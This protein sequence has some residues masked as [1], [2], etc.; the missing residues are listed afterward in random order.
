MTAQDTSATYGLD[1]DEWSRIVERLGREPSAIE[2]KIF[3]T[4]WSEEV[5]FKSSASILK[6]IENSFSSLYPL[7]G[8][9][10]G[11]LA[12]S[13]SLRLIAKCSHNDAGFRND[14]LNGLP[15][16]LGA[17]LLATA[18]RGATSLGFSSRF[19]LPELDKSDA[20]SRFQSAIASVNDFSQ[21]SGTLQSETHWQIHENYAGN[22]ICDSLCIGLRETTIAQS[23]PMTDDP[24]LIIGAQT[25]NERLRKANTSDAS[26]NDTTPPLA[27]PFLHYRISKALQELYNEGLLSAAVALHYGGLAVGVIRLADLISSVVEI[28]LN[29]LP[30]V[31]KNVSAEQLLFS[32]S[33]GR[34]LLSVSK[35]QLRKVSQIFSKWEVAQQTCGKI[36]STLGLEIHYNH[37]IIADIPLK[38]ALAG[39]SNKEFNVVKFP[40]MLKAKDSVSRQATAPKKYQKK[41]NDEWSF[42]RDAT[43]TSSKAKDDFA[44]PKNLADTWVDVLAN[45]NFASR[46]LALQRNDAFLGGNALIDNGG[47]GRLLAL[48]QTR[49]AQIALALASAT[50]PLYTSVDPYLGMTHSVAQAMRKIA[51]L[52]ATPLG[53][54][55]ALHYGHPDKY[56]DV[57]DLS[58]SIRALGD[59]T[60]HWQIPILDGDISLGNGSEAYPLVATPAISM[61]GRADIKTS[62]TLQLF[63][64]E[65]NLFFLIGESSNEYTCSEYSRYIHHRVNPNNVPNINFD[66]E[67]ARAQQI[68]KLIQLNLVTCC[69]TLTAG[70]LSY[71]LAAVLLGAQKPLGAKLKLSIKNPRFDAQLFGE[72]AGRY[73]LFTTAENYDALAEA[74]TKE[75]IP[76]EGAGEV[77][78]REIELSGS[79]RCTLPVATAYRIWN[80]A[81]ERALA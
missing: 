61:V 35:N 2:A 28:D 54:S 27:D 67:Y 50:T 20:L 45:L 26:I 57:C 38:F 63:P 7:P 48:R 32:E 21:L 1:K 69:R 16:A 41:E 15:T 65:G 10:G 51:A 33:S 8:T 53:I 66:L 3:A 11:E 78:G 55:F 12:I 14:P 73:L 76:I 17:T 49:D 80:Q 37:K 44:E 9:F 22:A 47:D 24:I 42:I 29:R 36:S 72:S 62:S 5:S 25:G 68:S 39:G 77:T 64:E 56:R 23:K 31:L 34:I 75:N 43:K 59:A 52:G 71:A 19:Y 30:H 60:K 40:P 70:G 18:A 74:L 13:D 46:K 58:E 6:V 79:L 81:S 4:L